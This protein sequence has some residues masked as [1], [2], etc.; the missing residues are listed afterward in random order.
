MYQFQN[1]LE[2]LSNLLESEYEKLFELESA[3]SINASPNI[4]N[5]ARQTIKR[6]VLPMIQKY[7][8]EY[9]SLLKSNISKLEIDE[10]TAQ[11][12]IYS[13]ANSVEII[14]SKQ[15]PSD[16]AR[17]FQ[18]I[19]DKLNEPGTAAAAKAKF[20]VNLIPGILTYEFELDT[21]NSIR[22][23]FQPLKQIFRVSTKK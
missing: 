16:V 21:E 18:Q 8:L 12:A 6:E 2:H 7:E 19:L 10:D 9:Y 20:A 22:Q 5:E 3:L 1:R 11:S 14:Q 23:M 13:L 17:L 15:I 4:K